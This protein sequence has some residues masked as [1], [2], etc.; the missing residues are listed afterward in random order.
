MQDYYGL[1]LMAA[2]LTWLALVLKLAMPHLTPV[3]FD[4]AALSTSELCRD[5]KARCFN[6]GVRFER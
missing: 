5:R 2:A 1:H 3:L 4:C 6:F